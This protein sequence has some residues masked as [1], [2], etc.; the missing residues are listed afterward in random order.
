MTIE[1]SRL[2]AATVT[3]CSFLN[4]C[5]AFHSSTFLDGALK[6]SCP[7]E[8]RQIGGGNADVKGCGLEKCDAKRESETIEQCRD[9]CARNRLCF[10]FSW[11]PLDADHDGKKGCYMYSDLKPDNS[12]GWNQLVCL[13]EFPSLECPTKTTQI[14][15]RNAD[16]KGC[17]LEKCTSLKIAKTIEECRDRCRKLY[18]CNM[19]TWS[20]KDARK[21]KKSVCYLYREKQPTRVVGWRQIMCAVEPRRPLKCLPLTEQIGGMHAD[22]KGCGLEKCEA[23]TSPK[24]IEECHNKCKNEPLCQGF[25]WSPLGAKH[26]NKTM[27]HIY[28]DVKPDNRVTW[29]QIICRL[30]FPP[31]K[32]P[33]KTVQVGGNMAGIKGCGL[34]KC[35]DTAANMEKCRDKCV[36]NILCKTFS[37]SPLGA[38]FKDKPACHIYSEAEPNNVV[39]TRQIVCKVEKRG[40]KCPERTVQIGGKNADVKGCGLEKCDARFDT[41]TIEECREKCEQNDV[42]RTFSWA[43][44][45][46]DKSATGKTVCSLYSQTRPTGK[47]GPFQIL[48][49]V[50]GKHLRC[51]TG[52]FQVGG[53]NAGVKA[54]GGFVKHEDRFVPKTIQSC[55]SSCQ[56]K[57]EQGCKAFSWAPKGGDKRSK[58]KS[59]CILSN[60][61]SPNARFGPNQIMCGMRVKRKLLRCPTG[62][63]QVGGRNSAVK[64]C[65]LTKCSERYSAEDISE[66][67][68]ACAKQTECR[69]F[70]WSSKGGDKAHPN[71]TVCTLQPVAQPSATVLPAA[72]MCRRNI[73]SKCPRSSGCWVLFP[74]GC[75][76]HKLAG[77]KW[78]RATEKS[79]KNCTGANLRYNQWCRVKNARMCYNAPNDRTPIYGHDVRLDLGTCLQHPGKWC[80]TDGK[81]ITKLMKKPK[82]DATSCIASVKH[83]DWLTPQKTCYAQTIT[84]Q[85]S[86]PH[87]WA[88]CR[89]G[90]FVTRLHRTTSTDLK[91]IDQMRCCKQT[92]MPF[93]DKCYDDAHVQKAW[94]KHQATNSWAGCTR[95][96]T[97]IVGIYKGNC[98]GLHCIEKMRCCSCKVGK[99]ETNRKAEEE[100]VTAASKEAAKIV[101]PRRAPW[102]GKKLDDA[103]IQAKDQKWLKK[104]WE[105]KTDKELWDDSREIEN[106]ERST[107][108]NLGDHTNKDVTRAGTK[109]SNNEKMT[110]R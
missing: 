78:I 45:G 49:R 11:S 17:G 93:W 61:S 98:S 42:C 6:L 35:N 75:P 5:G 108:K 1:C 28:S 66:C 37:W 69:A 24:T 43:P 50:D 85:W 55:F 8:T 39:D 70:V 83:A 60:L 102:S 88:L 20:P 14:G 105:S 9:Q 53:R 57:A 19:F 89:Q 92:L 51:P 106:D 27:C 3:V 18:T 56:K 67:S 63:T 94:Q 82:C 103:D 80:G 2:W 86:K 44:P 48:C 40:L 73:V 91:G 81:P 7:D 41:T 31:L 16:V 33:D 29:H 107:G 90:Y 47:N 68:D 12:V 104:V 71:T 74:D 54:S 26:E 21:K 4:T 15:G 87:R 110:Q 96:H 23:V 10:S 101:F 97:A 95:Q 34:E 46:G 109:H 72:I 77:N 59:V 84:K 79:K 13:M 58:D 52:S 99:M 64:G 36:D 22:V 62:T 32:C 30:K 100:A 65:G 38:E 76:A 25:G